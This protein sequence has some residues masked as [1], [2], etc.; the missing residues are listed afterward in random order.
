MTDIALAVTDTEV[1]FNVGNWRDR[2]ACKG[3][4][5]D[6][7][8]L[9]KSQPIPKS[10]KDTCASC[11]VQQECLDYAVMVPI[12]IGF[13]GGKS[14]KQRRPLRREYRKS[15]GKYQEKGPRQ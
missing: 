4:D 13:F 14:A 7:F 12:V 10:V 2:A 8:F 9:D 15:I 5:I 11:P 3:M 1:P 6:L